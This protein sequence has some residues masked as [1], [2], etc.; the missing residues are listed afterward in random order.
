MADI[1]TD[2]VNVKILI[3]RSIEAAEKTI[4]IANAMLV[5]RSAEDIDYSILHQIVKDNTKFIHDQMWTL[6]LIDMG[7]L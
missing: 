4:R 3:N 1:V 2:S 7:R 5:L 6:D